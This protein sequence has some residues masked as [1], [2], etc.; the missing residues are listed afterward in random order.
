MELLCCEAGENLKR[1][2]LDP[3][4]INDNRVLENLLKVEEYYTISSDYM[5]FQTD[6]KP[7]MRKVVTQ[8]MR[9]VST[10]IPYHSQQN[11][12]FFM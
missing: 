10:I 3:V 12:N 9:E 4:F 6:I 7:F 1:A 2:Y 8:W 5:K 11:I